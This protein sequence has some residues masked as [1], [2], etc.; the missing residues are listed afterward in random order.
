MKGP[1]NSLTQEKL[2]LVQLVAVFGLTVV[3][4][5]TSFIIQVTTVAQRTSSSVKISTV[6]PYL[7]TVMVWWTVQMAAMRK[8]TVAL[9]RPANLD[10]F[11]AKMDA[12]YHKVMCVMH[13][14]TAEII[15]MSRMKCAVS[16]SSKKLTF[17]NQLGGN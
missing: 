8:R 14:T 11:N 15:Q 4:L 10:S 6:F 5:K 17:L 3:S 7:G 1:N 13:R 9:T 2:D 16:V 12:A